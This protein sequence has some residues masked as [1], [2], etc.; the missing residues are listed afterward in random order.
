MP[1]CRLCYS[2]H[3]HQA[4]TELLLYVM[5]HTPTLKSIPTGECAFI[6]QLFCILASES[7]TC[8][9]NLW[10]MDSE[11][12]SVTMYPPMPWTCLSSQQFLLSPVAHFICKDHKSVTASNLAIPF[13]IISLM[14]NILYIACDSY[15][16]H[17]KCIIHKLFSVTFCTVALI[18]IIIEAQ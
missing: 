7:K 8:D 10:V 5:Q 13:H 14:V 12:Q 17:A 18:I 6:T 2:L 11:K 1:G 16:H 3:C 4:F 15:N 9:H